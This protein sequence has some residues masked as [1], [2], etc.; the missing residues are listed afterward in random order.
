LLFGLVCLI[1]GIIA[2]I[3]IA[4][5]QF[6][7]QPDNSSASWSGTALVLQNLLI[8]ASAAIF[9]FGRPRTDGI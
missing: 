5:A 3:W 6:Y 4:V 7:N 2:G 9:K 8:M 1:S